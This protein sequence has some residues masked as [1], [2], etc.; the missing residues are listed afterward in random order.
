MDGGLNKVYAV[1]AGRV[2]GIYQT[3][4]EADQQVYGYPRAKFRSFCVYEE[5]VEYMRTGKVRRESSRGGDPSS[6]SKGGKPLDEQ[7]QS[8]SM[9]DHGGNSSGTST[10]NVPTMSDVQKQVLADTISGDVEWMLGL[11]CSTLEVGRPV[12]VPQMVGGGAEHPT[13]YG[14]TD[15]LPKSERGLEVVAYGPVLPD[16]SIT[17]HEAARLMLRNMVI[18]TGELVRKLERENDDLKKYLS[19]G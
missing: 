13:A 16:E 14:F 2:P 11:L 12:F 3:W 15:I 4:E 10:Q 9:S 1:K 18:A 7:F 6:C 5:A 8:F 19:L 17:R